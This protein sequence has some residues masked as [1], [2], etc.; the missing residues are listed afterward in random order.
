MKTLATPLVW[1]LI[2]TSGIS[3]ASVASRRSVSREAARMAPSNEP[4]SLFSMPSSSSSD[5]SVSTSSW[6]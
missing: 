4:R 5:S 1:R 6:V 3:E 2:A